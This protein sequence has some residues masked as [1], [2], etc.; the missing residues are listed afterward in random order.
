M[1]KHL[2]SPAAYFRFHVV[3]HIRLSPGPTSSKE[4]EY[5]YNCF[6]NLSERSTLEYF[7]VARG[8]LRH[9]IFDPEIK[10][11][12]NPRQCLLSDPFDF[13]A[14]TEDH[15]LEQE[16]AH[17]VDTLQ[18]L[19]A[20]PRY[21]YIENDEE[22]FEN[23]LKVPFKHALTSEGL[24]YQG[25]YQLTESTVSSPFVS[26]ASLEDILDIRYKIR[27]N[28]QKYHKFDKVLVTTGFDG[29]RKVSFSNKA[30]AIVR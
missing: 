12:F 19:L 28:F 16:Q 30:R 8:Q 26:I 29:V 22:F 11:M 5:L 24:R 21:S 15:E 4:V 14:K 13:E 9:N 18:H 25:K 23:K 6:K 10:L 3:A 2:S 7:N 27:H 20:L 1:L 17:M